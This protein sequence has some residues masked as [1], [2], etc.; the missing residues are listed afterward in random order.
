MYDWTV[1]TDSLIYLVIMLFEEIK[2]IVKKII[3]NTH[4]HKNKTKHMQMKT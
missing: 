3:K 4:S 2:I 1:S